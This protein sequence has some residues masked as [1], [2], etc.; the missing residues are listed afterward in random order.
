MNYIDFE[1][2]NK[3]YRLRLTTRALVAL[4][5]QIGCNPLAIFGNGDSIPTITVMVAILHASLQAYNHGI[6]MDDAYDI[7]DDYLADGHTMTD[8]LPVI[9]ALYRASGLI[10]DERSEGGAEKNA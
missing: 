9:I 10:A 7:F 3:A 6:T 1:A 8:F 2:G 4:E 5:K